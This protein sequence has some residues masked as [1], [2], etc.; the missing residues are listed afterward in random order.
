MS[1]FAPFIVFIIGYIVGGIAT[2]LTMYAG[3]RMG[4]EKSKEGDD[5]G[6]QGRVG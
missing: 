4:V 6:S 1:N 5:A 3:F 2:F